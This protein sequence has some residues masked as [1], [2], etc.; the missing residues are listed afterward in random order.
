M[1]NPAR[2]KDAETVVMINPQAQRNLL[3]EQL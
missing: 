2:G 1:A 3:F